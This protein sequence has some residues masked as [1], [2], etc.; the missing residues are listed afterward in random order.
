MR[1]LLAVDAT[2]IISALIGGFSREILFD[3]NFEFITTEFTVGEVMNYIPYIAKKTNLPEEFITFLLGLLPLKVYKK[4]EYRD[5]I[6]TA[7]Q[8]IADP[9]D[10]DI[11]ALALAKKCPLWSNDTD[12]EGIPEIRL[13]K[14]KDFA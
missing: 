8:L 13:V 7:Q 1:P 2:P 4:E 3:H 11:L 10:V 14:T 5:Y 9:G 6:P 12:F